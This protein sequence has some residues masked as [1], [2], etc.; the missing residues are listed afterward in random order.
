M[1]V[2]KTVKAFLNFLVLEGYGKQAME[3]EPFSLCKL[4]MEEKARF[5]RKDRN[6]IMEAIKNWR[7]EVT[8]E[9]KL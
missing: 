1:N 4:I 5:K 2:T 9:I 3:M 7:V 6:E 8:A